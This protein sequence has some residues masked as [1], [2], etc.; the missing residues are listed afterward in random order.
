MTR[1]HGRGS[2]PALLS[3]ALALLAPRASADPTKDQCVD[4]DTKAQSLR[5]SGHLAEA[6]EQLRTCVAQ[7]CPGL[8]R[9]DCAQRLDELE[10]VQPTIVFDA[11]DSAGHDLAAVT[12]RI[13]SQR[14]LDHLDGTAVPVDP[15]AHA[16]RFEAQGQAPVEEQLVIREGEKARRERIQFGAAGAAP[17]A[18]G[19]T[20][21]TPSPGAS[22]TGEAIAPPQINAV[23][24]SSSSGGQ[25]QRTIGLVAGGTGIASL[26]VG[27]IFGALA[28]SRWSSAK[29]ACPPPSCSAQSHDQAESDK[30]SASTSATVSTVGFIAGGVLVA[31]GLALY[32]TAPPG[33][34]ASPR[35]L[36]VAPFLSAGSGGV[37]LEG[38]FR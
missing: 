22:P 27:S 30:S 7:A 2:V 19:G 6:R 10:H 38:G 1:P 23:S 33:S 8:V 36:R 4:A 9:D 12:V 3:A 16:F 29:S 34:T 11:Q 18:P 25:T 21:E 14:W 17:A 15:G 5:R 13:D 20:V 26:V 28:A 24:S 31:G 32:L 35:G 37:L